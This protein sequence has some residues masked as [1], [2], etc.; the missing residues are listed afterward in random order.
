MSNVEK[1]ITIRVDEH[2]QPITGS[3]RWKL[4]KISGKMDRKPSD[5]VRKL[6]EEKYDHLYPK[7]ESE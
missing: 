3:L 5:V 4:L 7:K 1:K 2:R 6:I